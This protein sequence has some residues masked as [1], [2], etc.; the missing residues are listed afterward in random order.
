[1]L[2]WRDTVL[3]MTVELISSVYNR[4]MVNLHKP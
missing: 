1:M 4:P 3:E 2:G